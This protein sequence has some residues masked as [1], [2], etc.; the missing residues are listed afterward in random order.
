MYVLQHVS[1]KDYTNLYS[2]NDFSQL[3]SNSN[4]STRAFLANAQDAID[5]VAKQYYKVCLKKKITL[6]Y[7]GG[8]TYDGTPSGAVSIANAH[9]WKGSY[10][11]N[12]TKF[13]PKKL[14]YPEATVATSYAEDTPTNSSLFMCMGFVDFQVDPHVGQPSTHQRVA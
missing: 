12:L 3:L 10:S 9:T 8:I 7:A 14:L 2:Q 11:L 4:G 6:R 5:P 13:V 1:L